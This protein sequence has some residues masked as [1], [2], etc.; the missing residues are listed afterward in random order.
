M[1]KNILVIDD[2]PEIGETFRNIFQEGSFNIIAKYNGIEGIKSVNN[3]IDLIVSDVK[4]PGADGFEVLKYTKE[5]FPG[6]PIIII[7]AFGDITTAVKA[8]KSGAYDFIPKPFNINELENTVRRALESGKKRSSTKNNLPEIIGKS[9]KMLKILEFLDT[10]KDTDTTIIIYGES[11]TGKELIAQRIHDI[12]LRSNE[13]YITVNCGAIPFNLLESELFGYEKGAFTG[14]NTE[15]PGLFET[16][17]GGSIFLDEIGDFHPMLQ[18]KLLR[19]IQEGMFY[20][21]GAVKPTKV[22]TRIIA[23]TNK[24]IQEMVLRGEF[25]EDLYY[26]LNI[27]PVYI[28]PLRERKEDIPEL[29]GYFMVKHNK[30]FSSDIKFSSSLIDKMIQYEWPGNIREL[31]NAVERIY[32]CNRK[33][34]IIEADDVPLDLILINSVNKTFSEDGDLNYIRMKKSVIFK[35]DVN[36]LSKLLKQSNGNLSKASRTSGIERKNL[37]EKVKKYRISPDLYRN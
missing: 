16:A 2:V 33:K 10:V 6:I 25:R 11:G 18:V 12:S 37:F 23:A 24:N 4:M 15:K 1:K 30:I 8:V 27:L 32:L 36:Y 21:L 9:E 35:F 17:S 13:N 7:T 22:N 29:I 3:E 28:P 20:R 34:N 5:K 19:I 26:R 14:A 31:Q